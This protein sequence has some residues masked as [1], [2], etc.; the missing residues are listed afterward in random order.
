MNEIPRIKYSLPAVTWNCGSKRAGAFVAFRCSSVN[1]RARHFANIRTSLEFRFQFDDL[2]RLYI[3]VSVYL[4]SAVEASLIK[5]ASTARGGNVA[6]AHFHP[7]AFL[8][9]EGCS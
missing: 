5:P 2:S 1:P 8:S 6:A 4:E 9:P 3:L 7:I